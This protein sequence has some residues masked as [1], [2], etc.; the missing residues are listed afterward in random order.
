MPDN[1]VKNHRP[2]IQIGECFRRILRKGF[3]G[4]AE[5]FWEVLQI[6]ENGCG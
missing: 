6:D 4:C 3:D 1:D 5:R 2:I